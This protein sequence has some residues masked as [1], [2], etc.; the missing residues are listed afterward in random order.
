VRE[1]QN[2]QPFCLRII[3]TYLPRG[4]RRLRSAASGRGIGRGEPRS[5]IV[6]R[7]AKET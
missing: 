7:A 5:K 6:K 1:K 3:D 2:Y 4:A